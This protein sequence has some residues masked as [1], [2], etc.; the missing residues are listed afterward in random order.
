MVYPESGIQPMQLQNE[1]L[2]V[3][4]ARIEERDGSPV[5]EIPV[6]EIELGTL[7]VGDTYQVALLKGPEAT[8]ESKSGQ[9]QQSAS[10]EP[11]VKK[12]DQLEVEIDDVGEQGDGIARVGPG[13]VV[14]VSDA[15][16]G[17]RVT[18]EVTK[19]RENFGFSEV[20]NPE[21]IQG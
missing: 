10:D 16:L 19:V 6:Q 1:L 13:Y 9:E 5:L 18:I 21:P 8:N 20:V 2:T 12:G 17:D 7:A 11:P 3:F 14:F 4:S 15:S